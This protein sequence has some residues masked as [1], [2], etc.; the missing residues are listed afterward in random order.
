[1]N[2][3]IIGIFAVAR[4]D[5]E[6]YLLNIVGSIEV[7]M[8]GYLLGNLGT[9]GVD[10]AELWSIPSM[11]ADAR[12]LPS[13]TGFRTTEGF[14]IYEVQIEGNE[15]IEISEILEGLATGGE[16]IQQAVKGLRE[17][18]ET[19]LAEVALDI[20]V[21]YGRHYAVITVKARHLT[22]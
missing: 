14:P 19:E 5:V 22:K 12:S 20:R 1:M 3:R 16:D 21:E 17:A 4:G 11:K 13:P 2:S 7:E 15:K 6:I 8:I 9:L 18:M 10:I